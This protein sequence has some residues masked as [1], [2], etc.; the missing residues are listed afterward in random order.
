MLSGKEGVF[1]FSSRGNKPARNLEIRIDLPP[2][3]LMSDFLE[4]GFRPLLF[5]LP[6]ISVITLQVPLT[7]SSG[8]IKIDNDLFS[9]IGDLQFDLLAYNR[10]VEYTGGFHPV[11]MPLTV[12]NHKA[13]I[14]FIPP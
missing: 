4:A 10:N 11:E 14:L 1:F 8:I 7:P 3:F 2:E 6:W 13:V 9:G 5:S 12:F